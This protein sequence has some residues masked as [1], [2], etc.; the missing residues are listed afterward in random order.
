MTTEEFLDFL[1]QYWELFGPVG[2]PE[3]SADYTDIKI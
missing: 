2:P 1:D 3:K